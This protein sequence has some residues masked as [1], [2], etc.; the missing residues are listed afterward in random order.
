MGRVLRT[1]LNM[2]RPNLGS[3]VYAAQAKQKQHHVEQSKSCDFGPGDQVWARDF[4]NN[5]PKWILGVV[6]Q[7]VG[8][9]SYMSQF[10]YLM[11]HFGKGMW[12]I[13][14]NEGQNLIRTPQQT[15][16]LRMMP[17]THRHSSHV[18]YNYLYQLTWNRVIQ[19]KPCCWKTPHK[20]QFHDK[21]HLK[22]DSLQNVKGGG[23]DMC[24]YK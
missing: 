6:F 8:P 4:Q 9:V 13:S 5:S 19:I 24:T 11:A 20:Q 16:P 7:N 1:R 17:L 21:T 14:V 23:N 2:L 15:H 3:T 18:P 22:T 12:T 10:S